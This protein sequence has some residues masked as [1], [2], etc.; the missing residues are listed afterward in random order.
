MTDL[1]P[2]ALPPEL[3]RLLV[4]VLCRDDVPGHG[5][6]HVDHGR[7]LLA[8]LRQTLDVNVPGSIVELGC[9]AGLTA[10][11]LQGALDALGADRELHVFDSFEGLP[12]V[13]EMDGRPPHGE[14]S[15]RA[16]KEQL[17]ANFNR[18]GRALPRIH[19]GWFADTL[20]RDLPSPVAFAH[21]DA[22]LYRSTL[23]A[24]THLWP[25]LAQGG[26]VVLHDY[27]DPADRAGIPDGVRIEDHVPYPGVKRAADAFFATRP[28]SVKLLRIGARQGGQGFVRKDGRDPDV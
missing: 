20:P 9:N 10:V 3:E 18:F 28:E 15:C 14:G 17:V 11:L 6:Q 7:H 25:R 12:A 2:T 27:I 19:E 1:L 5:M 16:T 24:L 13:E 22:D 4:D 26:V 21:L 23:E 8:L